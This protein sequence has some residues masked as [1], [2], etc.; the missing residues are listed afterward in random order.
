MLATLLMW[1]AIGRLVLFPPTPPPE[2]IARGVHIYSLHKGVDRALLED[3]AILGLWFDGRVKHDVEYAVWL[4]PSMAARRLG[5]LQAKEKWTPE[6]L[7]RRWE[8]VAKELDG[9]ITFVVQL[10]AMPTLDLINADAAKDADQAEVNK[11]RFLFTSGPGFPEAHQKSYTP[12]EEDKVVARYSGEVS[13]TADGPFQIE[14]K[15]TQLADWET[16][17]RDMISGF[18]WEM[19]CPMGE[20]FRAEYE[21]PNQAP[22]YPHGE[23]YAAWY[24]VSVDVADCVLHPEGFDLRV[25]SPA[26]ERIGHFHLLPRG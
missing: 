7:Q 17:D 24:V 9:R 21:Q 10:A 12:F 6:E 14:P 20:P 25:F 23:Y 13:E 11:V 19:A 15:V 1:A 22:D 5:Y 2:E 4:S 26:K 18:N 3:R 8:A 16:D